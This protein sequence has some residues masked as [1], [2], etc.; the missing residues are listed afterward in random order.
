MAFDKTKLYKR[1]AN[2]SGMKDWAYDAGADTI[3]TVNTDGY[4]NAAYKDLEVGDSIRVKSSSGT[5]YTD[6]LVLSNNYNPAVSPATGSVD[7]SD[8]VTITLTDGD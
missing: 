2:F 1:S 3:A 5:V 8:G 7:V 4:F 6:V